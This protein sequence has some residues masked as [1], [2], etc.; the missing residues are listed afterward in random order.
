MLIH[1]YDINKHKTIF[2]YISDM[3][4]R[5]GDILNTSDAEYQVI[6]IKRLLEKETS[7][8]A[9]YERRIEIGVMECR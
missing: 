3:I 1:V 2:N 6:T 9:F 8:T 4:P 7:I 5:V